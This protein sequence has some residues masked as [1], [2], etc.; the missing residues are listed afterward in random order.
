MAQSPTIPQQKLD[1]LRGVIQS[2]H[3]RIEDLRQE[4]EEERELRQ[5]AMHRVDELEERVQEL[6]QRTD[7]LSLLNQQQTINGGQAQAALVQHIWQKAK[8]REE[9]GKRPTA[10]L[11]REAAQ[12]ALHHPDVHRTT[13]NKWMERAADRVDGKILQYDGGVLKVNLQVD[14]DLPTE[15]VTGGDL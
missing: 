8:R 6:D 13:I 10:S 14:G 12:E 3:S 2:A 5:Q 15:F 11:D 4:L 9:M 1:D 7:L